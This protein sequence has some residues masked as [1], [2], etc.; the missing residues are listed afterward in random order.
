[1]FGVLSSLPITVSFR[2]RLGPQRIQL[3][4]GR[5]TEQLAQHNGQF[6]LGQEVLKKGPFLFF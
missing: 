3:I 5:I 1:M 2:R 4:L 6:V